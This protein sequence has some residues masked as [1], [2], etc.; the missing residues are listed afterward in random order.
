MHASKV[1]EGPGASRAKLGDAGQGC[2]LARPSQLD[3]LSN[4]MA[5]RRCRCR[6]TAFA[7]TDIVISGVAARQTRRDASGLTLRSR[8][9]WDWSGLRLGLRDKVRGSGSGS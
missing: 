8:S 2:L 5:S 9:R 7:S 3:R 6:Q 1:T 4:E